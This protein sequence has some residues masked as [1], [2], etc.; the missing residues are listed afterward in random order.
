[1]LPSARHIRIKA[2]QQELIS[3]CGGIVK[4]AEIC[5]YGKSTVGRWNDEESPEWMPADAVDKLEALTGKRYWTQAWLETRGM[6]LAEPDEAEARLACLTTDMAS[7]IGAFGG[8]MSEWAITA[9]DGKATP[10]EATRMRKH[11]PEL[12]ELIASIE[13][14]LAAVKAEGGISLVKAS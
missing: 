12:K 8:L 13:Q 2:A 11:L 1:M 10:A 7:L 5:N 4:T 14:G 9:A 6:K 3:A